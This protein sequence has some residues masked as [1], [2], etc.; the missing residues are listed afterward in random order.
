M[1]EFVVVFSTLLILERSHGFRTHV[2]G[3]QCECGVSL[4]GIGVN[5][6]SEHGRVVDRED[7]KDILARAYAPV[8]HLLHVKEVADSEVVFSA[9]REYRYCRAGTFPLALGVGESCAVDHH[10]FTFSVRTYTIDPII[11]S[12]PAYGLAVLVKDKEFVLERHLEFIKRQVYLPHGEIMI[13]HSQGAS[14][15]PVS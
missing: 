10:L 1:A 9:D 11:H 6:C 2:H 12:F 5:P 15:I 14:R 3:M 4:V 8:H 13:V 7:L